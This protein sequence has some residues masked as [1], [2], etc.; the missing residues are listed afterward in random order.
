MNRALAPL[1]AGVAMLGAAFW[2]TIER[3]P[4]PDAVIP[5]TRVDD[6][7]ALTEDAIRLYAAG[8]LARAC[9]RFS[10]AAGERPDSLARREN[11]GRCFETWGWRTLAQ[12]RPE[13]AALLF[14]QGLAAMPE[15]PALLKGA[16]VSAVHAGR[17]DEALGSLEASARLRA[18]SQVRM[19]LA[20]LYDHRDET[21][22]A[23]AH[24]E[25]LLAIDSADPDA[26]RLLD[27]LERER[28]TESDFVREATGPF[29]LRYRRGLDAK[30]RLAVVGALEAA[31]ARV[32]AQLGDP[33]P[34]PVTVVLYERGQFSDVTRSH[35][36]VDGLFDGRIRLPVGPTLPRRAQLERIVTHEYAHAVIHRR[37]RGRAPRWLHEGL[38]QALEGRVADAA[39]ASGSLTLGGLETLVTEADA[40]RARAGYELALYVVGDLLDRGGMESMRALLARLAAGE[41]IENAAERVY[42]WRLTELESQWRRQ[43]G[44]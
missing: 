32:V 21:A 38:A 30:R 8:Q 19:L 12:G 43:L 24:L 14:G 35:A 3:P 10:E 13:E 34:D 39:L 7:A 41:T 2:W 27:K 16:G 42:G 5:V 40:R 11:V 31:R 9:D 22:R 33:G 17:T 18:D 26:R 1:I 28:R 20:R 44:G 37:A 29:V 4:T 25:A 15:D 6:A 23:V 36:W